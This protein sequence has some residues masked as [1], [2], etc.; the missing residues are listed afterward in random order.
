MPDGTCHNRP[1]ASTVLAVVTSV[2]PSGLKATEKSQS[3]CYSGAPTAS[4]ASV[5]QTRAVRSIPPV[6]TSLPSGLK[7][8]ATTG[9]RCRTV[10]MARASKATRSFSGCPI[11]LGTRD[12]TKVI[13]LSQ[14]TCES[15]RRM[16]ITALSS[17][18][19][20]SNYLFSGYSLPAGPLSVGGGDIPL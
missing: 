13:M 16:I 1:V 12:P 7:A 9:P 4:P 11:A 15:N 2:L 17:M 20:R 6:A 3:L 14:I 19:S 10:A 5:S 8:I 18:A